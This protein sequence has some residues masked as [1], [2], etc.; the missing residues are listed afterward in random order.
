MSVTSATTLR[1][2]FIALLLGILSGW[3]RLLVWFFLP[4][5]QGMLFGATLGYVAGALLQRDGNQNPSFQARL[6]LIMSALVLFYAGQLLVPAVLIDPSTPLFLPAAILDGHFR[7]VMTGASINSFTVQQ[8]PLTPGWWLLFQSVDAVF[9]IFL[10]MILLGVALSS[11]QARPLVAPAVLVGLMAIVLIST[12]PTQYRHS[13]LLADWHRSYG[14]GLNY[15]EW[16]EQ[17]V[18]T[19]LAAHRVQ[20]FLDAS[21]HAALEKTPGV[22]ILRTL[23]Y[24]RLGNRSEALHELNKTEAALSGYNSKIRID[25]VRRI[26]PK[27]LKRYIAQFRLQLT[28][29]NTQDNA[30]SHPSAAS[31]AEWFPYRSAIIK[32]ARQHPETH[33]S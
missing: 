22:G 21:T 11:N 17:W 15:L 33:K 26:S 14:G 1:L 7:E 28:T 32:L 8:G 2:G 4:G 29:Q 6:K 20:A 18:D 27:A 9:F 25:V 5:L 10:G 30:Q 31:E 16:R 19:G 23:A 12:V 3:G 24:L 13:E